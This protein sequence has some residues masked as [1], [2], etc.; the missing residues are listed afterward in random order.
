MDKFKQ[1]L[2]SYIDSKRII[3]DPMLCYAYGTDASVYRITP[4]LVVQVENNQEV[5][6]LTNLANEFK[7]PITFRAAGTSLSG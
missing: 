3:D 4:K 1:R 5:T 7:I 6:A 2:A